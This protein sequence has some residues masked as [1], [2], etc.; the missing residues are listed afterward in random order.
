MSQLNVL[1]VDVSQ[2]TD[3]KTE[4]SLSSTKEQNR[5]ER[6]SAMVNRHLE[7]EKG[8]ESET[9][10][11]RL[12]KTDNNGN[13]TSKNSQE[14]N[15]GDE[16]VKTF[17]HDESESIEVEAQPA[18][19]TLNVKSEATENGEGEL[20]KG[21]YTQDLFNIAAENNEESETAE[22][23]EQSDSDDLN[24]TSRGKT[25][26]NKS[27]LEKS[28]L[29]ISLVN[30]AQQVLQ[31]QEGKPIQ[32]ESK[33]DVLN[34]V[35]SKQETQVKQITKSIGEDSLIKSEKP[36]VVEE[37]LIKS[38]KPLVVEERLIK[39]EKPLVVEEKT[40]ERI[41]QDK[42]N[43]QFATIPIHE[44]INNGT[45]DSDSSLNKDTV[46]ESAVINSSKVINKDSA[47]FESSIEK[48]TKFEGNTDTKNQPLIKDSAIGQT[49]SKGGTETVVI[50][51]E[52]VNAELSANELA[53]ESD[54]ERIHLSNQTQV[55]KSSTK[56]E[57]NL[58]PQSSKR[59]VNSNKNS[60]HLAVGALDNSV[61]DKMTI[62][63]IVETTQGIQAVSG[64]SKS[65]A[66]ISPINS[67][68]NIKTPKLEQQTTNNQP[69]QH[70][71]SN[72][73]EQSAAQVDVISSLDMDAAS[74]PNEKSSI[75]AQQLNSASTTTHLNDMSS[76]T[77]KRQENEHQ[78]SVIE[79]ISHAI[80]SD[81]NIQTKN[82]AAVLN[83]TISIFRKDFAQAVKDK[84][85][86]IIS[87]KLQQFDIRLDPPE[88][89]NVHVRVNLQNE[90]A[91]VNFMVQTP[92]A[93]EAF[94]ENLHKLKD[95]LAEHGVDVGDANVEQQAQNSGESE[96]GSDVNS[97]GQNGND[98]EMESAETVLSANLFKSSSSNIDYYA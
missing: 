6:F 25:K 9:N 46:A 92:Q 94:E 20:I 26:Q 39:S 89:G 83:E 41:N 15:A 66:A 36:L 67:Q 8:S 13:K 74:T 56:V 38:E 57:G 73:E 85:M 12:Q 4:T 5:D 7:N 24:Q 88:L 28:E 53:S 79:E 81:N 63:D 96:T 84:V 58:T 30:S 16:K 70:K 40:V 78:Q 33:Q 54:E 43:K 32:T 14:N 1:P 42:S 68:E 55:V 98:H 10:G 23:K 45:K 59:Q 51:N 90:Q 65:V 60:E 86:V 2:S 50:P 64:Q 21:T 31:V 91:V 71:G 77:S 34:Q 62:K 18:K 61:N 52:K 76:Q 69:E 95:M 87:Q 22:I 11:K 29:F 37:R 82:N 49:R 80:V 35:V 3:Y 17:P 75:F 47:V 44:R 97:Q 72:S 48:T 19:A 27:E 93:K